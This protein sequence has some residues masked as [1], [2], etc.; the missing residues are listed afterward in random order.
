ME[1][2]RIDEMKKNPKA[3]YY[4]VYEDK[5]IIVVYKKRDVLSI[6]TPDPKTYHHNLFYYLQVYTKENHES[7]YLIHRLDFE[8]SGLMIFAKNSA[9]QSRIKSSFEDHSAHR[10]YEG[11]IKESLPEGKVF[12]IR[13]FLAE[14]GT[15]VEETNEGEGKEAITEITIANPIQIGTAIAIELVT[16]RKNQIRLAVHSLG[17]T[18]LGDKRYSDNEAKRMYLNAYRLVF[19]KETGLT[20]LEFKVDPLWLTT[21]E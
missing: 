18:L 9:V 20:Q 17:L 3:P 5:D 14:N 6:A 1:Q 12:T 10:Y 19:P 11:V 7:V 15:L 4:I 16:G 21:V 8:T 2:S 13:Q